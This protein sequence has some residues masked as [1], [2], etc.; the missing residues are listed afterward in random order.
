MLMSAPLDLGLLPSFL[1]LLV[2]ALD[3]RPEGT[4]LRPSAPQ[5][6]GSLVTHC[7]EHRPRF[8][9][10]SVLVPRGWSRMPFKAPP[11]GKHTCGDAA[12]GLRPPSEY[13]RL[14]AGEQRRQRGLLIVRLLLVAH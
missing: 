1:V 3:L 10:P 7:H 5:T 6:C 14:I 4:D 9:A 13:I 11:P 12:A 8:H 2:L